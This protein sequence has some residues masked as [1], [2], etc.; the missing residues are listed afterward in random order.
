MLNTFD[1]IKCYENTFWQWD[2]D[3]E[4]LHLKD[5]V[6]FAHWE[7]VKEYLTNLAPMGLPLFDVFAGIMAATKSDEFC[8]VG[9]IIQKYLAPNE[10]TD[11]IGERL[12]IFET[13]E[14]V[15]EKYK[16]GSNRFLFV[17]TI[18]E[19]VNV[20]MIDAVSSKVVEEINDSEKQIYGAMG[21]IAD[22][23][24]K[25]VLNCFRSLSFDFPDP[26]SIVEA[27]LGFNMEALNLENV[28]PRTEENSQNEG[29]GLLDQL[30]N[31]VRTEKIAALIPYMISGMNFPIHAKQ[32]DD[33]PD[34]GVSDLS[35]KGHFD[36]LIVSEFAYD[37]DY[38][39]SRIVNN[40]ALFYQREKAKNDNDDEVCVLIDSSLYMWGLPKLMAA[41]VG[42]TIGLKEED[43]ELDCFVVGSELVQ[44]DFNTVDGVLKGIRYA[45][46]CISPAEGIDLFAEIEK[47]YSN[48]L[49]ITTE[50]SW[51][52]PEMMRIREESNHLFDFVIFTNEEA[53]VKVLKSKGKQ[54]ANF[55]LD[56]N[57][58]WELKKNNVPIKRTP[59]LSSYPILF[60]INQSRVKYFFKYNEEIFFID[61]SR[62]VFHIQPTAAPN[63]HSNGAKLLL[64][65]GFG[66]NVLGD[67][68]LN[69]NGELELLMFSQR[70]KEV[71]IYNLA[72]GSEK[73]FQFT[74]W[75]SR[76]GNF[77][78]HQNN[79]FYFASLEGYWTFN[80][81]FTSQ[82]EALLLDMN[83]FKAAQARAAAIRTDFFDYHNYFSKAK[84]VYV[85]NQEEF[86][87]RGRRLE[88]TIDNV[89]LFLQPH[90]S[91]LHRP[92]MT[93]SE[94]FQTFT[95]SSGEVVI[96]NPSGI[97][98]FHFNEK[99][100]PLGYE[101]RLTRTG[102]EKLKTV[103]KLRDVTFRG[104]KLCKE[105]IDKG[106]GT[107][108]ISHDENKLNKIADEFREL[109]NNV[110]VDS[111]HLGM[112]FYMTSVLDL[113]TS[114]ASDSF[115]TGNKLF[116]DEDMSEAQREITPNEF[117]RLYVRPFIENISNG[118]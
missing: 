17:A 30:K 21:V 27:M 117:Y 79:T 72:Q 108:M 76:M 31:E 18:L 93:H 44:C 58:I 56:L 69:E 4:Y 41:A 104:L 9:L 8:S 105:M 20:K 14:Q 37:D 83:L 68:G 110:I 7:D 84:S 85:S 33:R 6:T 19:K 81:D 15:D 25:K 114:M 107:I 23:H 2:L 46:A 77:F 71:T 90:G 12:R 59:I 48:T 109:G 24:F 43:S 66:Y 11:G 60:P 32:S 113:S 88:T 64:K 102:G 100:R 34:G 63:M 28:I 96:S 62:F 74:Q 54:V 42:C 10:L 73:S 70:R 91:L 38:F 29:D 40:E 49:F 16:R 94:G 101:L 55:K 103:K 13:M 36:Q 3:D 80:E 118:I 50:E 75:K 35:N 51:K 86:V 53:E 67:V 52:R 5:G 61:K 97:I 92:K 95:F 45:D 57:T 89:N 22:K 98:E 39:L 87:I 106:S 112:K 26:E 78:Y 82:S 1:Y 65:I 115:F 47:S 111:L 116:R 99:N